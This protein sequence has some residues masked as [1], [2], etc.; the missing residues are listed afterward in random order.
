VGVA[1]GVDCGVG[2]ALIVRGRES[3]GCCASVI[4]HTRNEIIA[5]VLEKHRRRVCKSGIAFWKILI[6]LIESSKTSDT[7]LL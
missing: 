6:T 4:P 7:A 2:D 1:R 5:S 3:A